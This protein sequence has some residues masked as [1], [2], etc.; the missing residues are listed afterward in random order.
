MLYKRFTEKSAEEWRQIY[1]ALQL[2]EFLIKN[3]SERVIDDARAHMSLLK[4]LRQFAHI[5]PNGKDQGINV[6]TRAKELAELLGDVEKIRAERKKAKMNRDKYGG[7][8]S[9]T[10][11]SRFGISGDNSS[12]MYGGY[13]NDATGYGGFSGGVYGDGGGFGGQE[14]SGEYDSGRSKTSERFEEYDEN[15]GHSDTISS[16]RSVATEKYTPDR[17]KKQPD[18]PKPKAPEG[19]LFDFGDEPLTTTRPSNSISNANDDDFDDFQSATPVTIQT[20]AAPT[21]Q[22]ANYNVTSSISSAIA[23][24]PSRVNAS[25][26]M[27]PTTSIQA[28]NNLLGGPISANPTT[29][30]PPL[31]AFSAFTSSAATSIQPSKPLG[32]QPSG[33]NY[34]QPVTSNPTLGSGQAPSFGSGS[35]GISS[36]SGSQVSQSGQIGTAPRKP[37]AGGDAF[38]SLLG[39]VIGGNKNTT[40][41][42]GMSMQEMAKQKAEVGLYG[43][44]A[45]TPGL[46]KS[47]QTTNGASSAS[48][49]KGATGDLLF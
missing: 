39:G 1:K 17:Y 46:A 18:P 4:M 16:R 47:Q 22:G 44:P 45:S 19:D 24:P 12:S 30:S 2:L 33:P 27:Q 42:S 13:G 35:T 8:E 34:F 31:Q 43:A 32:Y 28:M 38:A 21:Y 48:N 26:S 14:H 23:P 25:S 15:E 3:G 37:A 10:S 7:I 5:D 49:T 9:G 40:K 6:R 11:S 36:I 20:A 41:S 29:T